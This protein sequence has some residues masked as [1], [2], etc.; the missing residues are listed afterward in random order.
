MTVTIPTGPELLKSRE[1][2]EG[3]YNNLQR[4]ECLKLLSF[5]QI[6]LKSPDLRER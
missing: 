3:G 1:R 2:R 5:Y 4:T 6:P